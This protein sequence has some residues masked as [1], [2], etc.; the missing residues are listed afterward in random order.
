MKKSSLHKQR[1]Q[2]GK[3]CAVRD[4][5]NAEFIN[6]QV[7][8]LSSLCAPDTEFYIVRLECINKMGID[9]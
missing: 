5:I 1:T 3:K 6:V 8:R 9:K 4:F 2:T 7:K